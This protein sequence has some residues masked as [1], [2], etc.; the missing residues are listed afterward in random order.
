MITISNEAISHLNE[1]KNLNEKKINI[2]YNE[3]TKDSKICIM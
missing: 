2:E 1:I 3:I